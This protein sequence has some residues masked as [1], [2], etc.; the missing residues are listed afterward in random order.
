MIGKSGW[1]S[2]AVVSARPDAVAN[3]CGNLFLSAERAAP[4]LWRRTAA[5]VRDVMVEGESGILAIHPPHRR[6]TYEPSK[7][8]AK[9]IADVPD[10]S[11]VK[12]PT[13]Y[14]QILEAV[15]A[16]HWRRS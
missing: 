11:A 12:L 1:R 10:E 14:L 5:D 4:P 16:S 2:S 6:P 7:R 9:A 8:M 13:S 15:L 3:M